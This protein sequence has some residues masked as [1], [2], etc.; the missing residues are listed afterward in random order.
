MLANYDMQ[1]A[2]L[3]DIQEMN[4][5]QAEQGLPTLSGGTIASGGSAAQQDIEAYRLMQQKTE[6]VGTILKPP[7]QGGSVPFRQNREPAIMAD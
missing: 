3:K 4:R 1:E 7:G 2:F 6:I 5:K